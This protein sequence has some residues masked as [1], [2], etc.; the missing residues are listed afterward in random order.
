MPPTTPN[1]N[2]I[3]SL[4]SLFSRMSGF[5]RPN[6]FRV[7]IL[8]PLI[9]RNL[10]LLTNND[11]FVNMIQTPSQAILYRE[12]TMSPSGGNIQVPF[13]RVFDERFIIE[14]VVDSKWNIRKFFD[15]WIDSV[16]VNSNNSNRDRSYNNSSRVNYWSDI[17]GTVIIEAL[18]IN[19]DVNYTITLHDSYPKLIIPSEMNNNASNTYLTLLVDMNYRYYTVA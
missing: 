14:F 13:K 4:V 9:L 17:V 5:Q 12:D 10:N 11:I 8:P 7:K 16:F 1:N 2:N 6:R 3:D 18:G 15:S 19:G